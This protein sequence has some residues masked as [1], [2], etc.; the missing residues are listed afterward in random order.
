[1]TDQNH[2]YSFYLRSYPFDG[3][4][5]TLAHAYYPYQF[6]DFGGDIHFDD[7]EEWTTTQFPLQENGV[8]FF[9]VAVRFPHFLNK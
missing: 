7:D 9:T 6:A 4:G 2:I 3:S 5:R 8:D 1:M